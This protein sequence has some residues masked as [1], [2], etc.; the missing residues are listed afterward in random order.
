MLQYYNDDPVAFMRDAELTLDHF[1]PACSDFDT[2]AY[3]CLPKTVNKAFGFLFFSYR[4]QVVLL[5][6][7]HYKITIEE[8]IKLKSRGG[9][10][11]QALKDFAIKDDTAYSFKR[12][13]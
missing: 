4:Q 1:F 12:I 9:V 10:A 13:A 7:L 8:A 6:Q 2:L 3:D 5:M 11:I